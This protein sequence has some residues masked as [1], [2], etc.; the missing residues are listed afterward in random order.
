MLLQKGRP[1]TAEERNTVIEECAA[2]CDRHAQWAEDKIEDDPKSTRSQIFAGI[3]NTTNDCAE[4][5]RKLKSAPQLRTSH[6]SG[7]MLP[8]G[9]AAGCGADTVSLKTAQPSAYGKDDR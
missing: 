7:E 2:I 5:V 6:N 8:N 9:N 1:M 3:S 4:M